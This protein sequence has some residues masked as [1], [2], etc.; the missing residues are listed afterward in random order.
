MYW[1]TSYGDSD[2]FAHPGNGRNLYIDS[3]PEPMTR[4][5][6]AFWRARIQVY[7]APFGLK[8]TDQVQIHHNSVLETITS[9]SGRPLFDDSKQYWYAELPNHGVKVPNLGVKI[10]VLWSFGT[11]VTVFVT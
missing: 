8:R 10:L 11:S 6:G 7:D 4:S 1:D 2:T 3:H 9:K 5:D